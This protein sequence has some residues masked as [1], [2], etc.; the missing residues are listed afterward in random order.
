MGRLAAAYEE[1]GARVEEVED[2]VSSGMGSLGPM[3]FALVTVADLISLVTSSRGRDEMM[4][5]M[6]VEIQLI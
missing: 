1:D 3:S 5:I 2:I 4:R 6:N